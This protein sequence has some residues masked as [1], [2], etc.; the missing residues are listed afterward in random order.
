MLSSSSPLPAKAISDAGLEKVFV[1]VSAIPDLGQIF[2]P[3]A[4]FLTV[5]VELAV[6]MRVL[7]EEVRHTQRRGDAVLRQDRRR[8][9][10][11]ASSRAAAADGARAFQQSGGLVSPKRRLRG[12]LS[13][14]SLGVVAVRLLCGFSFAERFSRM[15]VAERLFPLRV[16]SILRHLYLTA[17]QMQRTTPRTCTICGHQGHFLPCGTPIRPDSLCPKC[18]SL[19]RQRLTKL[20][21]DQNEQV[22][23]GK[24]ILHFAPETSI[25]RIFEPKASS[26]ITADITP[27]RAQL[28]LNIENLALPSNSEDVVVC[29]HVLEHVNDKLALSE[30]YRVMRPNGVALLMVPMIE[31]WDSSYENDEV[32][33]PRDRELHYGQYDHVRWFG[34]DFRDRIKAAGF[35]LKEYVSD[36]ASTVKYALLPGERIFIATKPSNSI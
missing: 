3:I 8:V 33:T 34:G 35:S 7:S 5:D 27:G 31:G 1:T 24:R 6:F 2:W 14:C 18:S 4:R 10:Q 9:S 25:T 22:F 17:R 36:G 11:I 16:R 19:E 21:A 29:F 23:S 12:G 30:L 32:T 13:A 15:P 20:W 28:V 26:Y